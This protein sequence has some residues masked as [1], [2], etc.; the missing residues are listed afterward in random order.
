MNATAMEQCEQ[1]DQMI[2]HKLEVRTILPFPRKLSP[3]E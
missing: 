1:L 3:Y 2:T